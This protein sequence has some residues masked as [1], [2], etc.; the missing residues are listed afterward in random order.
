VWFAYANPD[1]LSSVYS[2]TNPHGRTNRDTYSYAYRNGYT[3]R[4]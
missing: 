2:Y 3:W 4:D 1:S